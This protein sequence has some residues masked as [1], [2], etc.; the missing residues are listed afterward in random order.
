M[1]GPPDPTARSTP[2]DGGR[3]ASTPA[4]TRSLRE[5]YDDG[6]Q[7]V[8]HGR[9]VIDRLAK[10]IPNI[11]DIEAQFHDGYRGQAAWG[12]A[13]GKLAVWDAVLSG[14]LAVA[15]EDTPKIKALRRGIGT[16][17]QCGGA[18]VGLV[19]TGW[20][21]VGAVVFGLNMVGCVKDTIQ[22]IEAVGDVANPERTARPGMFESGGKLGA[23]GP[24]VGILADTASLAGGALT[25][26]ATAAAKLSSRHLARAMRSLPDLA[27]RFDRVSRTEK[28]M[29]ALG[30]AVI[31]AQTAPVVI[32]LYENGRA[33]VFESYR[34]VE[35]SITRLLLAPC[36]L[37]FGNG[38]G[39]DPFAPGSPLR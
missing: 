1:M 9:R 5:R 14:V 30:G 12:L 35:R 18:A 8:G 17:L 20:T 32:E 16:A 37:P 19:L 28:T 36:V 31:V 33:A 34:D 13:K 22:F 21:G 23:A 4:P 10:G 26:S 24:V 6:L 2:G 7:R 27:R 11:L 15:T 25:G 39:F 3:A 29:F 38:C